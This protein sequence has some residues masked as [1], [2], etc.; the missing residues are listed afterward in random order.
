MCEQGWIED[1]RPPVHAMIRAG[2]PEQRFRWAFQRGGLDSLRAAYR[3]CCA[4]CR[5]KIIAVADR[6]REV[7]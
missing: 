1:V 4:E 3:V 6:Y 2:S 7:A 5:P